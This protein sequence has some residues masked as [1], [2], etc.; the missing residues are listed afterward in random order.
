MGLLSVSCSSVTSEGF[1]NDA[2]PALE[3]VGEEPREENSQTVGDLAARIGPSVPIRYAGRPASAR[4]IE[5]HYDGKK[6]DM[7][8]LVAHLANHGVKARV[9]AWPDTGHFDAV[10]ALF[11]CLDATIST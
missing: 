5:R 1:E 8:A 10:S 7:D 6:T 9:E 4:H 3:L 2:I 11:A